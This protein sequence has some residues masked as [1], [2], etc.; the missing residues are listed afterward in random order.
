VA[1][2]VTAGF[3]LAVI[4]G[5]LTGRDALIRSW[6][7]GTA[8]RFNVGLCLLTAGTAVAL[9]G[10]R[11]VGVARVLG[12]MATVIALITI[13][14]DLA[15]IDLRLDEALVE[16]Q[17]AG[18]EPSPPGRM[19][20]DTALAFAF[21]GGAVVLA[22]SQ[23]AVAC[24]TVVPVLAIAGL[25]LAAGAPGTAG[26]PGWMTF[27][28]M[29]IPVAIALVAL[30]L[31]AAAGASRWITREPSAADVLGP[32]AIALLGAVASV[33]V[34]RALAHYQTASVATLT[35]LAAEEVHKEVGGAVRELAAQLEIIGAAPPDV[36]DAMGRE[37][38][39]L[40]KLVPGLVALE[41][42]APDRSVRHRRAFGPGDG[43]DVAPVPEHPEPGARP[44]E[45]GVVLGPT[46]RGADG[47]PAAWLV[48]RDPDGETT[49]AMLA[50]EKLLARRIVPDQRYAI[51]ITAEG[52]PIYRHGNVY[53][54]DLRPW[55]QH[56]A[57]VLPGGAMWAVTV[58]PTLLVRTAARTAL[59]EA[60]LVTGLLVALLLG[61]TVLLTRRAVERARAMT[62]EIAVRRR[63][64]GEL[65]SLTEHLEERVAQATED[66]QGANRALQ[67][68][69]TLRQ[70]A[71]AELER[72]NRDLQEFAAFVSH[73]LKQPLATMALWI[74]LT[75][76][77]AGMHLGEKA[78]GYLERLRA[79][80]DR[81]ARLIDGELALA[82]VGFGDA[83]H[84]PV[85]LN[86]IVRDVVA[87]LAPAL[88][89]TRSHVDVGDLPEVLAD[90]TQLRRVFWNLIE[91]A[92]KY[93]RPDVPLRV[94]IEGEVRA[95]DGGAPA[96]TVRVRDNGRGFTV[97][98]GRHVFEMFRRVGPASVRGSGIGLA[99]CR[100]I[101]ERHG[102]SIEAEGRPGEGATFTLTLAAARSE[103]GVDA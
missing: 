25:S 17:F 50:I 78:E 2:V 98:Q 29:A 9:L 38:D 10:S 69:N 31:G 12:A 55:R 23:P 35:S 94:C 72:S 86:R 77:S 16:D 96:C 48:V 47:R 54:R 49:A 13:A 85:E 3:G 20:P 103:R 4:A 71:Q 79:T 30:A 26:L 83:M 45:P 7:N 80:I 39:V 41:S 42:I 100:R 92:I 15:G 68:E 5:W 44:G 84:E 14:Q 61:T 70:D 64:E 73:E 27:A 53:A 43:L 52:E 57:I 24:L 46:F 90:A 66:L 40:V 63:V 1:G 81:L 97:E 36:E 74:D 75:A 28:P 88:E 76:S 89:R 6:P 19:L 8:V 56:G 87:E 34:W 51:E 22:P 18:A 67:A 99:V 21:L 32:A 33:A 37:L 82:Q 101:L 91:N 95:D 65:R 58:A 60:V 11:L 62:G 102:G 59:P 93:R